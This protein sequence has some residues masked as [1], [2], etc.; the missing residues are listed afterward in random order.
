METKGKHVRLTAPE[1]LCLIHSAQ[2]WTHCPDGEREYYLENVHPVLIKG[3]TYLSEN[4]PETNCLDC[5]FIEEADSDG[6][7]IPQSC[8]FAYFRTMADLE[9]WAKSHPTHLAIFGEFHKMVGKYEGQLD[10]KLW[11]EVVVVDQDQGTFDYINC[12]N[13]TGLM[14]VFT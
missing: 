8:G 6:H 9:A 12:H 5:R 1:N 2:N 11:H 4:G 10:L 13:Q 7:P 3:M 14:R